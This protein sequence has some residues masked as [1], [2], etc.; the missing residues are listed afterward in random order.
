M[1]TI[2]KNKKQSEKEIKEPV[3]HKSV[4]KDV[5][6]ASLVRRY[7]GLYNKF[8]RHS[9]FDLFISSSIMLSLPAIYPVLITYTPLI[10]SAYLLYRNIQLSFSSFEI[11]NIILISAVAFFISTLSYSLSFN[12]VILSLIVT[13]VYICY[14]LILTKITQF[15]FDYI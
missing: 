9:L 12:F 11:Q 2:Q 8:D 15:D 1:E 4:D 6:W 13:V 3:S 14:S 10:V 5:S 7:I